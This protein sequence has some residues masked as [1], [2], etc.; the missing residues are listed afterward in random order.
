MEREAVPL[1]FLVHYLVEGP[2]VLVVIQNG[3]HEV[4]MVLITAS[5]RR[6]VSAICLCL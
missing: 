5:P 1:V 2:D 3:I 4:D 6:H